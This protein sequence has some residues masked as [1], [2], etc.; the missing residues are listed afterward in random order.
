MIYLRRKLLKAAKNLRDGIEPIEPWT[1][2]IYH[3]HAASAVIENGDYAGAI[4]K[5][6][7]RARTSVIPAEMV[8]A[9]VTV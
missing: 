6:K 1:P 7:E 8:A 2:E 5:A 3:Y 9:T 4:E